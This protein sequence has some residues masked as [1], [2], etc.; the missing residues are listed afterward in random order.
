M[1]SEFAISVR[2]V[3]KTYILGKGARHNTLAQQIGSKVRSLGKRE[4]RGTFDALN[5]V[6]FNVR[7]GEAVGIVGRN[8]AGKSTLLKVLTRV[9]PPTRG[10]IDIRGRVGS[11]L[12][13]GTGFHPELTGRENIYLNGSILGMRKDEVDRNFDDIV[14]F[15]EVSQFL[16][17]PVKRYSSGMYVRLAFAVAAHLPTEIMLIDEVLAVGDAAFKSRSITKMKQIVSEG[18]TILF[19]SHHMPSVVELCGRGIVLDHGSVAFD[20]PTNEAAKV[21]L[22]SL[23]STNLRSETDRSRRSGTGE[24]RLAHF[25]PVKPAFTPDETK[26]FEFELDHI[27]D[28]SGDIAISAHIIDESGDEI[29]QCD[30][31][32]MGVWMSGTTSARGEL[33]LEEPWLQ[34]G[35]YTVHIVVHATTVCDAALSVCN[36]EI[37]PQ[38]PFPA[39]VDKWSTGGRVLGRFD[40]KTESM[41]DTDRRSATSSPTD[42]T[43]HTDGAN[44]ANGAN[45]ANHANHANHGHENHGQQTGVDSHA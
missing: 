25:E 14:E 17:T 2:N 22:D 15:S 18:R 42:H 28:L 39:M 27:T 9:T 1:S 37:L 21:Y 44:H 32:A 24:F 38:Y 26:A 5:D 33:R 43:D 7:A 31:R 35:R 4:Q 3:G 10:E 41:P 13:I 34:P 11:L 6:S 19:V 20:G 12:E 30:S 23:A 45:G 36:F 40:W 8:G 16:E 29:V